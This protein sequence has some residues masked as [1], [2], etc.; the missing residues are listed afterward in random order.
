VGETCYF[1]LFFLAAR[2]SFMLLAGFF[3]VSFRVSW[4]LAMDLPPFSN[5]VAQQYGHCAFWLAGLA[6][7]SLRMSFTCVDVVFVQEQDW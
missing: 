6:R 2:F 5:N 3:L 7:L 4:P 1:F